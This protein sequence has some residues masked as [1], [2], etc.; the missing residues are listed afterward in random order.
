MHSTPSANTGTHL[1]DIESRELQD[2]QEKECI[3]YL[4][5]D[6]FVPTGLSDSVSSLNFTSGEANVSAPV[7]ILRF[8][9]IFAK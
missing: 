9:R 3:S 2:L 8:R 1:A 7:S 5:A 6:Y 4:E